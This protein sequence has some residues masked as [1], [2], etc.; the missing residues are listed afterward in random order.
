MALQET[1]ISGRQPRGLEETIV[2]NQ[3][4]GL[5]RTKIYDANYGPAG[6]DSVTNALETIDY[7]HHEIHAG[8]SFSYCENNTLGVSGVRNILFVTPDT[9][10][11]C[12]FLWNARATAETSVALYE[13]TTTSNNGT[14]VTAYNHNRNSATNTGATLTHTP[15]ITGDGTL[16]C[17]QHFGVGQ[18]GGGETRAVHEWVLKQNTKYLIRVTSEAADNDVTLMLD[19]YEHTNKN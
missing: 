14:G 7:A 10:K 4:N 16:L 19:W 3:T 11:W 8:N 15:T 13:T 17:V 2:N 18:R 1:I 9:T 5:Q 6:I 12:H